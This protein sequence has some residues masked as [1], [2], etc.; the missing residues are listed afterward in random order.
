M[1]FKRFAVTIGLTLTNCLK[2]YSSGKVFKLTKVRSGIN[3][4]FK[5][6]SL[7]VNI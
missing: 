1:A 4:M 2:G 7:S 6:E 5:F 3:N